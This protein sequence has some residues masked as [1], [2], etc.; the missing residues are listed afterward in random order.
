M[1]YSKTINMTNDSPGTLNRN[2]N[3]LSPA[4]FILTI[5]RLKFPNTNY[6]LQTVSVPE[7]T[8]TPAIFNT[9]QRRIGI[10]SDKVEYGPLTCTFLI[11]E[12]LQNYREMHDWLLAQ[13][14]NEDSKTDAKTRDLTLTA[15]TSNNT[16]NIA[17]QFVD[18]YPI[19]L[20]GMEFDSTIMDVQYLTASVTFEYSYFKLL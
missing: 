20:T 2:Y 12:D 16:A 6:H 5:D 8:V 14:I 3:Y 15:M 10:A 1:P 13:V 18:A 9:P 19:S 11:D 17:I 7:M 4:Q